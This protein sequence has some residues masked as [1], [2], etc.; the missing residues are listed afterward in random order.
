MLVSMTPNI[1]HTYYCGVREGPHLL[2]HRGAGTRRGGGQ[3]EGGQEPVVMKNCPGGS[4][5]EEE[6]EE[7]EEKEEWNFPFGSF[8]PNDRNSLEVRGEPADQKFFWVFSFLSLLVFCDRLTCCDPTPH[9]HVTSRTF[10]PGL[11]GKRNA[12]LLF[13]GGRG[14]EEEAED[15]ILFGGEG[16]DG[17]QRAS[18][19][20]SSRKND[21]L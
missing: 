12:E 6:E 13:L 7:E 10:F 2:T 11:H 18:P 19:P 17:V 15:L 16:K 20:L 3:E 5:E 14:G 4:G 9:P 1:F 21:G 8:L